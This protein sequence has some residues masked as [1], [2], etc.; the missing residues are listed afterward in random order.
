MAENLWVKEF[1]GAAIVCDKEGTI[2]EL[3][4]AGLA[5]NAEKGGAQLIGKN[6]IDCH[7]AIS[8]EEAREMLETGRSHMGLIEMENGKM[9]L[10]Y[11]APWYEDGEYQ[12]LV[13][14]VLEVP[15]QDSHLI[16]RPSA[17]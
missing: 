13:E 7:S 15:P 9:L 14:L 17:E 11:Y 6:A 4:D 12:G 1:A 5:F 10:T 3:N 8:K 16:R 2:L